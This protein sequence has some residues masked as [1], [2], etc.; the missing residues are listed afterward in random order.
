MAKLLVG[1]LTTSGV[2]T[3][4][5]ILTKSTFTLASQNWATTM[6]ACFA[7]LY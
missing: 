7:F 1:V 5:S 3:K 2:H 4:A 6:R